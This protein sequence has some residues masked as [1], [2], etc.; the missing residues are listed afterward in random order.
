MIL[1]SLIRPCPCPLTGIH[2]YFAVFWHDMTSLSF[3]RGMNWCMVFLLLLWGFDEWIYPWQS[4]F[5]F[6]M[7]IIWSMTTLTDDWQD[8]WLSSFSFDKRMTASITIFFLL[9]QM[10]GSIHDYLLS[11]LTED[12][13]T[14]AGE[15]GMER[16]RNWA[17]EVEGEQERLQG[18]YRR[19]G[20]QVTVLVD[21][22]DPSHKVAC[23][24]TQPLL[25]SHS[26]IL[27][28]YITL[29]RSS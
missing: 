17:D 27:L 5:Y 19:G 13:Q 16:H 8:S 22:R 10:I 1:N 23:A 7:K 3:N 26:I 28:D 12:L 29:N 21:W 9:W 20:N 14:D 11:I 2:G 24:L 6:D 18:Y 25:L 15:R 4:S